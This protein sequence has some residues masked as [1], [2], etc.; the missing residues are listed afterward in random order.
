MSYQSPIDMVQM[1]PIMETVRN[2]MDEYVLRF[3]QKVCVNV[4]QEELIKALAYDRAQYEKGYADGK[5]DAV[6]VFH[7]RWV[8]AYPDI[9][10]NPMFNYGICSRCGFEQSISDKLNYCPNCGAIMDGEVQE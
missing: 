9:E 3:V 1:E 8:S 6:P 4:D 7:A 10:P 5:R 2:Q